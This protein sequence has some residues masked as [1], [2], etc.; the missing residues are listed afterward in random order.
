MTKYILHGGFTREDNPSN[1]AFYKEFI[2]DVP[3]GGTILLVY[4]AS[5]EED[6]SAKFKGHIARIEEQSEEKNFH[7]LMATQEQF[8]SQ[9]QQSNAICFYG[10]ST[11]KLIKILHTYPD[12]KPLFEGKTVAGS[13]AGT[14][15]LAR[16]GP[17]HHKEEVREG[18][19]LVPIRVVCHYEVPRCLQMKRQSPC[20]ETWLQ[21]MS[22]FS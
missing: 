7:F 15:A 9:I 1:R 4:F 13:S 5:R 18:L 19:G 20:L 8:I 11:S 21:N 16:L 3:D 14:Y 22:L 2:R 6:T 10:G 12:L 17:S